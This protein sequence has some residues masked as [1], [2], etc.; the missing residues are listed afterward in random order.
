MIMGHV[1]SG[2][3]L[4]ALGAVDL[5]RGTGYN[6]KGTICYGIGPENHQLFVQLQQTINKFAA[7]AGFPKIAEDGKIGSESVAAAPKVA[8]YILSTMP[9]W[10]GDPTLLQISAG[11]TK[12]VLASKVP[13]L[14]EIFSRAAAGQGPITRPPPQEAQPPPPQAAETAPT[15]P[16]SA[17]AQPPATAPASAPPAKP[18]EL[19]PIFARTAEVLS[20]CRADPSHALCAEARAACQRLA[21]E[22]PLLSAIDKER[23]EAL[24][25]GV[26]APPPSVTSPPPSKPSR[27]IWWIAGTAGI[28]LVGGVLVALILRRPKAPTPTVAGTD[29]KY[30]RRSLRRSNVW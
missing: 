7:K 1:V 6:C 2:P 15:A 14:L 19:P 21:A 26:P 11:V 5:V 25:A 13:T 28:L 3:A 4:A 30:R 23:A 12:E 22:R 27:L 17:A 8:R 20:T 9:A 18:V 10:S 29:R 16:P 24:C